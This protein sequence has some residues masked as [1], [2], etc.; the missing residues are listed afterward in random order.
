M[1]SPLLTPRCRIKM[2]KRTKFPRECFSKF[3]LK[4]ERRS[5][6]NGKI[7]FLRRFTFVG[8]LII[9]TKSPWYGPI[10]IHVLGHFHIIPFPERWCAYSSPTS[11]FISGRFAFDA[12]TLDSLHLTLLLPFAFPIPDS[13]YNFWFRCSLSPLIAASQCWKRVRTEKQTIELWIITRRTNLKKDFELKVQRFKA[14]WWHHPPPSICCMT[15][16]SNFYNVEPPGEATK[17]KT[18]FSNLTFEH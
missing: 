9:Y 10:N 15:C 11:C 4:N 8:A 16:L 18:H 7:N 12:D 5:G 17:E 3:L 1:H 2:Q 13:G 14:D 6:I